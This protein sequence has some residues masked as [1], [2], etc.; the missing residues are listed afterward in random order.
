MTKQKNFSKEEKVAIKALKLEGFSGNHIAEHL[1]IHFKRG[2]CDECSINRCWKRMQIG[3]PL[4]KQGRP[5][6]VTPAMRR[7]ICR[8]ASNN[9]MTSRE[10][11]AAVG[12]NHSPRTTR[13]ILKA[14]RNILKLDK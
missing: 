1:K 8:L 13:N 3:A 5:S 6:I 4:K 7:R 11:T 2:S 10:I 9:P 12:A 14:G